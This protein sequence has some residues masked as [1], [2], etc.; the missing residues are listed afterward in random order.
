[1]SAYQLGGMVLLT[2]T[3]V[4]APNGGLDQL[5]GLCQDQVAQLELWGC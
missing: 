2:G 3:M 1:M 4:G 5:A